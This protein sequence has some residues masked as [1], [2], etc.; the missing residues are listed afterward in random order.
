V[1]G[2]PPDSGNLKTERNFWRRSVGGER[3]EAKSGLHGGRGGTERARDSGTYVND[4]GGKTLGWVCELLVF[5]CSPDVICD[6]A[7]LSLERV[8]SAE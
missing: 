1:N 8:S 5:Y 4:V 7:V 3:G 6:V 2:L